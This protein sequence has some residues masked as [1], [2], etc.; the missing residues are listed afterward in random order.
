MVLALVVLALRVVTRQMGQPALLHLAIFSTLV[1]SLSSLMVATRRG[2]ALEAMVVEDAG[3]RFFFWN[4]VLF[5]S[6][7]LAGFAVLVNDPR[8]RQG[9]SCKV[10]ATWLVLTVI[11]YHNNVRARPV[12]VGPPGQVRLVD[13]T[14]QLRQQCE[15]PDPIP[16]LIF[17]SPR[18]TFQLGLPQIER[19]CAGPS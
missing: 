8:A 11:F 5:L 12:E 10:L 1:L 7:L 3:G 18:W 16:L 15:N 13:Y 17:G 9:R 14:D 4:T 19:L 6:V 2:V